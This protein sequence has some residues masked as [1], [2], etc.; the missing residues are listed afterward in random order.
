MTWNYFFLGQN[1][2]QVA[3]MLSPFNL[4]PMFYLF[5]LYKSQQIID[6]LSYF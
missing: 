1:Y 5:V 6:K 4:Q 2:G 3:K